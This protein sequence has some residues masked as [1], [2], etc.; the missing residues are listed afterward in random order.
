MEREGVMN[1]PGFAGGSNSFDEGRGQCTATA[2]PF[3]LLC[4]ATRYVFAE[5]ETESRRST[6]I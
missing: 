6:G 5:I 2:T 1:R 4:A 3:P